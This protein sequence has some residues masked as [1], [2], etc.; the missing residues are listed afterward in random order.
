MSSAGGPNS[1]YRYALALTPGSASLP[2]IF[3]PVG[4]VW[5]AS[6]AAGRRGCGLQGFGCGDFGGEEVCWHFWCSAKSRRIFLRSRRIQ[7]SLFLV[8]L[9]SDFQFTTSAGP[10][11][12]PSLQADLHLSPGRYSHKLCEESHQQKNGRPC[13][14]RDGS[15]NGSDNESDNGGASA[16]DR[17]CCRNTNGCC[18]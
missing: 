10:R 3:P 13:G 4:R 5:G 1:L 8:P 11:L 15:S 7:S 12:Y 9:S 16:T 17:F 6:A 14:R 2:T 18:P